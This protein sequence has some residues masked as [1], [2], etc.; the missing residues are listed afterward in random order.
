MTSNNSPAIFKLSTF[1]HSPT[2]PQ[3]LSQITDDIAK[4]KDNNL[5][6]A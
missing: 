3:V 5:K 2:I 1:Q 4:Q 6:L